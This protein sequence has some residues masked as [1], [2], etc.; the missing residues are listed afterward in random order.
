MKT[1]TAL[2]LGLG[3]LGS[4]Q[5]ETG[6]SDE[7]ILLGQSVPLSGPLAENGVQ[8][9][10]GI[11]LYL[12]QVNQK[13]GINGRK[14]ELLTL[15]DAYNPARAE[16]NTRQLIE[17]KQ[18]FALLG[19]AGT[20]S[21]Q[22]ALPLA[23]KSH[24][25]LI[26][27]YTGAESLRGKVSPVL[28]HL[29]A[30]YDDEMRKIVEHQATLGIKDIA[31]VYQDDNFGKAGLKGFEKAMTDFKLKPLA[32]L[33]VAPGNLAESAAASAQA[34]ARLRPASVIL[35]TAGKVST[36]VIGETIKNGLRPQFIGISAVS[37]AQLVGDL[38]TD[39]AGIVIA[40]VV[41]SPW[42]SKYRIVRQYREALGGKPEDAHYA[43]LEG[44]IAGRVMVEGLRR[45]GKNLTR[46][47]LISALE[48]MQQFDLGD[49]I[50]DYRNGRHVGSSFI[51]LSMIRGN[52]QFVQ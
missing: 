4:A 6:V 47:G 40:Q 5:A 38:K 35:A 12:D 36:A 32:T 28:F 25:P 31:I 46:S 8:Y 21:T 14:I 19:Y 26:A 37:A 9:S 50:V 49:F 24:T 27:P 22:A 18:V 43:S 29:R 44:Y 16:E 7:R 2:L 10:K 34:L 42:S 20:G 51:D 15:D 52:G 17:D 1:I 45:A 41:P 48:G 13:G 33:A 11:R 39:A 3:L 23:E 30:G